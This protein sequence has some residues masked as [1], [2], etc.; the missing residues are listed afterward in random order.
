MAN[1]GSSEERKWRE[2]KD[3][4]SDLLEK[5][6]GA[7]LAEQREINKLH[8]EINKLEGEQAEEEGIVKGM[9]QGTDRASSK[10]KSP[11]TPSAGGLG[12]Y[13]ILLFLSIAVFFSKNFVAYN[14]V[15]S[16]SLSIGL[17]LLFLII[18][19]NTPTQGFKR[20][21]ILVAF[22]ADVIVSQGLLDFVP[23]LAARNFLIAFHVYSWMTLAVIF[24]IIGVIEAKKAGMPVGK[25][26]WVTV[27][28]LILA[29]IF[30]SFP[31]IYKNPYLFQSTTHTEYFKIAQE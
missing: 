16:F 24:L 19:T 12:P 1:L 11:S 14:P 6:S 29:G 13:L 22:F 10:A 17:F 25:L 15:I 18:T 3:R 31:V 27:S 28:M 23:D 21:L 5:G 8:G 2:K 30:F 26:Y 4:Y 7:T 20:G 9:F